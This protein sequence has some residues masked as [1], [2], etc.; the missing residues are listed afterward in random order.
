MNGILKTAVNV[1]K[2]LC[3]LGYPFCV[4]GGLALQRW[5]EPRMTV[6]IDVTVLSGFGN[7][8]VVVEQLLQNFSARIEDVVNFA[9]Q[10]RIAL[11]KTE[12]GIGLDVS[13]GALPFEERV[14]ERSSD[15]I[16]PEYGTIRTCSAEDLVI[17]KTFAARPQ[18][19]IDV[20]SVVMRHAGTLDR[21]L[22][23]A[24]LTPLAELKEEPEIL[25]QLQTLFRTHPT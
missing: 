25:E 7:E 20:Q 18:D 19:W 9:Q 3:S 16:I 6:D 4:I 8:S 5:G 21:E 11:L 14:M 12:E 22:I 10:N 24:E 15:W 23:L 17:L 2:T 1:N 13:L